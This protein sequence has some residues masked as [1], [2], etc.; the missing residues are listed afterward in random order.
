LVPGDATTLRAR[1]GA[2]TRI[3]TAINRVGEGLTRLD[4]GGWQGGSAEAFRA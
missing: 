3:G 2:M 4:D 1:A